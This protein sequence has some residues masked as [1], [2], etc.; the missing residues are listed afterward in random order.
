MRI[1]L[2]I[3]RG[4]HF[5]IEQAMHRDMPQHVIEK[6]DA[7]GDIGLTRT[8]EVERKHDVGF[9]CCARDGGRMRFVVRD[10]TSFTLYLSQR[11]NQRLRMFRLSH[12][13][14]D[15]IA[16]AG[17]VE[18]AHE[19][20]LLLQCQL[21]LPRIAIEHAA[22]NEIRLRRI[23]PQEIEFAQCF[24]QALTFSNQFVKIALARSRCL[25]KKQS[26]PASPQH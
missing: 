10:F 19:N 20:A 24:T 21:E 25:P 5:Q 14:A 1:D 16:Q 8:V 26:P 3:A 15:A 4:L 23:W 9:S 11:F 2:Q 13:D 6:A 17:L 22:Q 18:I 12:A 7:G